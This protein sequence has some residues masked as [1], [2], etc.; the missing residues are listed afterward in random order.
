MS[1]CVRVILGESSLKNPDVLATL[2][3][4]I[5][6]MKLWEDAQLLYAVSKQP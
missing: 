6:H 3:K 5:M 1:R 2:A 4:S